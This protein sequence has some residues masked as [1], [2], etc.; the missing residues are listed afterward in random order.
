M[1][2]L[3]ALQ[4]PQFRL[5]WLGRTLSAI[6]DALIPV[7][8]AFA[9]L[10]IGTP[11]ELGIV[12][13]AA[14]GSRMV[15]VL[16]G[17]VWADR[18]PRRGIL[19]ATDAVRAVVHGTVA[20]AFATEAVEVWHL[21]VASV[22]SGAASAFF[23]PASTGIVPQ[24][25]SPGRLQDANALLSLSRQ[26]SELFGPALAGV[27]VATFGYA[28]VFAIDAASVLASL[29][30]LAFMRPLGAVQKQAQSFLMDAREGIREVLARPWMRITLT[31]DA[32]ANFAI[33]PYLVLGPVVA[34]DHLDG[35]S[36]W[37]LIVA[38]AAAGGILGGLLVLRWK[39]VRPLVPAYVGLTAIPIALLTL[40]PPL[41][42]P[43]LMVG[44][45][46]FSMSI[47][48]GNTFWQTMEQQHVPNAVLGRV[49]SVSWMLALTIMP[50]AY[51]VT[52]PA[53]EWLG[54]RGT[55]VAAA[56]IGFAATGGVLLSRSV[57][58]LRRLDEPEPTLA[59][60]PASGSAGGSP[61]PAPPDPL[62]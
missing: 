28:L 31:A 56:V 9:V 42:L 61:V 49:D 60:S 34:R 53:S 35:A 6:G 44:A 37:G 23:N 48:V 15:F 21:I 16:V 51:A 62:P 36:D 10:E 29:A 40:V 17:G 55:L 38:A 24:I 3:G 41:P 20:L 12:L 27:L 43:L 25:V 39:P 58:E 1:S 33:A 30:C 8:L 32:F 5:L 4:E 50:I 22:L 52:G 11:T 19:I 57:R 14:M 54:V 13:G 46:L 7:A 26:A 18:L 2:R 45:A 47:V 59:P